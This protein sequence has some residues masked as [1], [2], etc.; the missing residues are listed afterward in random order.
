MFISNRIKNNLIKLGNN[1][2]V[3]EYILTAGVADYFNFK[4]L[5]INA[6]M[7]VGDIDINITD[8]NV[9]KK[10]E[11]IFN[12]K[13]NLLNEF[14]ENPLAFSN[15]FSG[16]SHIKQYNLSPTPF[17][18]YYLDNVE[19]F[20]KIETGLTDFY[21]VKLRYSYPSNTYLQS[22]NALNFNYEM[23]RKNMILKYL[24]KITIYNSLGYKL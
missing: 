1:F 17:D 15:G 8:I 9:L 4:R 23:D 18:I 11:E 6:D 16:I 10:F 13:I 14:D 20:N 3:D 5:K 22:V 7:D 21:D 24:K 2:S 12:S 19:R